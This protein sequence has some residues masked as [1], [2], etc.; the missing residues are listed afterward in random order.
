MIGLKSVKCQDNF[1]WGYNFTQ[2]I[3]KSTEAVKGG[4]WWNPTYSYAYLDLNSKPVTAAGYCFIKNKRNAD[5]SIPNPKWYLPSIRELERILRH[6]YIEYPEFQNNYYW[7]SAAGEDGNNQ[8]LIHTRATKAYI[9]GGTFK[10]YNSGKNDTYTGE[11]GTGG[12]AER[13]RS[14]FIRAAHYDNKAQ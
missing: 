2:E 7:S 1:Y 8:S 14:L 6:Y 11:N 5:G 10:Y 3:V 9:E 4:S 12:Y 13:T